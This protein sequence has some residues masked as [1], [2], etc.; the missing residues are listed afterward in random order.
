MVY[1]ENKYQR[2]QNIMARTPKAERNN[3][4]VRKRKEDPKKWSFG[5]L[6]KYYKVNKRVVWEIWTRE[7]NPK[8]YKMVLKKRVDRKRA[9][10]R[11]K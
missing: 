8:A 2:T 9:A 7:T 10:L 11:T 1:N 5:N 4:I 6:A 3:E